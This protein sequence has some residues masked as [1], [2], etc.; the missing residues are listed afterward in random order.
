MPETPDKLIKYF[1]P[2]AVARIAAVGFRPSSRVEGSR[3]GNHRSPFHGFAVEFAGHR[4]YVPGDDPRHIDWKVYYKAG[5]YMTKQYELE[6]NFVAHVVVDVSE[7]M[8]FAFQHGAKSDYAAFVAVALA[9]AV[10]AQSDQVA[11]T[12]FAE[13]AIETFPP[14][15]A[16][17]VPAK[18]SRYMEHAPLKDRTAVGR[19]L[20]LL[21]ERIG[22]RK[23]VFVL[24]DFFGDIDATF[25]GVKRLADNKNEVILL[26]LLDPLELDFSYPGRVELVELEGT[27]RETFEGR[28]IREG[29]ND[30]FGQYLERMR[31]ESRR[32]HVDYMVCSTGENFGLTLAKYLNTRLLGQGGRK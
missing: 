23:V 31:A 11:V 16:D 3:V 18:I 10:V 5:R 9:D 28:D 25:D 20:T 21:A 17:D 26:H 14:S 12:F 6:T 30:L 13:Q 7:S 4:Q 24:S 29:Y 22:R 1:D 15:S 2:D 8:K 27:R 32:H 19:V